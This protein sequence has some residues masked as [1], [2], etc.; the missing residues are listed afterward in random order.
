LIF[1]AFYVN[2]GAPGRRT[3]KGSPFSVIYGT[4]KS[5][6]TREEKVHDYQENSTIKK[7]EMFVSL[8]TTQEF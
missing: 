2:C 7:G 1:A 8:F 5:S 4:Y 6:E 3:R